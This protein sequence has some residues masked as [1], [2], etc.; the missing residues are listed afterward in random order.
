MEPSTTSSPAPWSRAATAAMVEGAIAFSRTCIRPPRRI[1]HRFCDYERL[2][3]RHD[4]EQNLRTLD[5]GIE[6]R[7]PLDCL[8]PPHSPVAATLD[9]RDPPRAARREHLPDG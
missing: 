9:R 2:A 5:D 3:R 1:R 8:R 4:R 6:A 7:Q